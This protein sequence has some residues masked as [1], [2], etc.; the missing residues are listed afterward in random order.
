MSVIVGWITFIGFLLWRE[1]PAGSPS[2]EALLVAVRASVI[3]SDADGL[4]NAFS[5]D[6]VGNSYPASYLTKVRSLESDSLTI[7][8]VPDGQG[9]QLVMRA[10]DHSGAPVCT[11][12]QLV[13]DDQRWFLDGVPPLTSACA[14]AP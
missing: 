5:T 7:E 8:V 11:A 4:A 10:T 2:P 6:T 14:A 3:G 1:P 9:Q 12:W 13:N